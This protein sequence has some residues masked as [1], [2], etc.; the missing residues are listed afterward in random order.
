[1]K[2]IITMTS[3]P[4][5]ICFVAE[6]IKQFIDSQSVKPDIFYLWLSISEFPNK[7]ADLP[8]ELINVCLNYNIKLRWTLEN[9]YCHKRWY[10]YPEHY[11]DTVISI[12]DDTIYSPKIVEFAKN[13]SNTNCVYNLF[14]DRTFLSI[15]NGIKIK[16]FFNVVDNRPSIYKTFLGQTI[17]PPKTF[18]LNSLTPG[19]IEIRKKYCPVC[20]E[21]WLN[22]FIKYNNTEIGSMLEYH[23]EISDISELNKTYNLLSVTPYNSVTIKDLQLYLVLRLKPELMQYWKH[24]FLSYKTTDFDNISVD[25]IH[26]II[27]NY[28]KVS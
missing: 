2:I 22:P 24:I 9:E 19:N 4:K 28:E 10:V 20:D 12:D 13:I 17:F 21:S 5:R 11:E 6:R 26:S 27:K 15:Y 8:P 16:Y 25:T 18:P 14:N 3:Y 7:E 1:M 23:N